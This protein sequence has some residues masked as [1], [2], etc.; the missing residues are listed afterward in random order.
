MNQSTY[1]PLVSVVLTT[2]NGETY[3]REQLN[4]L[5]AQTYPNIEVIAVDDRS[6]DGTEKILQEYAVQYPNVKVFVN[7]TNLGFIKNFEKGCRLSTGEYIALCDQDDYWLR[8]KIKRKMESIGSHSMIYCDSEICD[9]KLQRSG[10]TISNIVVCRNWY[11]C[12]EYA[13]FARI[14]GHTLLLKRSLFEKAYPFLEI[15]PHDWWLAFNATL[16]GGFAFLPEALVLYRQHHNNLYGMVDRKK[17]MKE[18]ASP[19]V[20]TQDKQSTISKQER[21][22][23]HY[24]KIRTRMNRFYN[25]CPSHLQKE[26]RVLQQLNKSY[27]SFSFL[28]NF[29]RMILFFQYYKLL[30]AT[31]KRSLIRK[32][33]F[34]LKM[35][36]TIK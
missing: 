4:S 8:D 16:E 20:V 27:Q 1:F 33:L 14:Y 21:K 17:I 19:L 26:K 32:Y 23:I 15:I 6:T 28:N 18:E 22:K 3:L 11:S 24:D 35:F 2:Y 10:K 30:L 5:L 9:D 12:L 31:K 13:V 7:E 34:C 36:T 25:Q 29:M